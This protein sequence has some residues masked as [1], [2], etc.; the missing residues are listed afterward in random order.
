MGRQIHSIEDARVRFME[1]IDVTED[2]H[3]FWKLCSTCGGYGRINWTLF[4]DTFTAHRLSWV[5]FRGPIPQDKFILHDISCNLP[6]CVNYNHLHLGD[7]QQNNYEAALFGKL[8]RS[9]TI[10]NKEVS[11]VRSMFSSGADPSW[12]AELFGISRSTCCKI[13]RYQSRIYV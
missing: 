5:L 8:H 9:R 7:M 11:Q 2:G 6:R 10:T 4:K 3:W 12:I 13:G 1:C